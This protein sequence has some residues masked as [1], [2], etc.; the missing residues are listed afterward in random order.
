M[1]TAADGTRTDQEQFWAMI[2]ADAQLLQ[3]EFAQIIAAAWPDQPSTRPG[4]NTGAHWSLPASPARRPGRAGGADRGRHPGAG[5]GG[6][7]RSP[8][9]LPPPTR[10]AT[11][12][13]KGR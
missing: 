12:D 7:Q 2:C 10:Q 11:H 13:P 8:P 4:A 6:R 5:S 3:S 1:A 9:R